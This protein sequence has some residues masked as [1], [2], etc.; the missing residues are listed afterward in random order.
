[1]ASVRMTNELRSDIR[2]EA[3]K[4]YSLANPQPKPSNDFVAAVRAAV[5]SSPEQ[6]FLKEMKHIGETRNLDKVHRFGVNVLPE[7]P[8]DAPTGIDLRLQNKSEVTSSYAS[9]RNYT[10]CHITF[11]TP[12]NNFLMN[13]S[14]EHRWGNPVMWINDMRI[15]DITVLTEHFHTFQKLEEEWSTAR[16]TYE[17]SIRDLVSECTT[18]KQLLEIWPAAESLVPPGKI[19][20]MHTKVTRAQRAA[21]IKE[22]ISFDPTIANQAVLTAKMLGG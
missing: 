13:N 2:R 11:S 1:M 4:A 9:Q 14:S 5:L 17:Q 8:K 19:Q 10:N 20:K 21:A 3:E 15:E 12:M 18:L 7:R 16:L 22:E 6:T